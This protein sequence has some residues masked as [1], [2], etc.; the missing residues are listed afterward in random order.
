MRAG[1]L[2]T[3]KPGKEEAYR[4]AHQAVW[5]ELISEA[6]K[7]GIRNH[8]SFMHDRMVFVYLE[9]DDIERSISDLMSKEVKQRWN[10]YMEDYLEPETITL[11]EVFYMG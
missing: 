11:D 5:P 1:Y 4:K 10:K 7:A 8:S 3:V 9:A 6:S 2:L